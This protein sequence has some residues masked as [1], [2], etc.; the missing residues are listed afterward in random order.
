MVIVPTRCAPG[1]AS[2]KKVTVPFPVPARLGGVRVIHEALLVAVQAHPLAA[3]TSTANS[4]PPTAT[5][6]VV[7]DRR[8]A[9]C[10]AGLNVAVNVIPLV[11]GATIVWEAAPP[12]DQ[13]L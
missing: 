11:A 9:H 13:E 7:V 3:M 5:D 6:R 10:E 2:I 1:L 8:T 12:S 4:P